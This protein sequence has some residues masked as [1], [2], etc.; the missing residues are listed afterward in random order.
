[1]VRQDEP[2]RGMPAFVKNGTY[3]ETVE[4]IASLREN[5]APRP[6]PADLLPSVTLCHRIADEV[7]VGLSEDVHDNWSIRATAKRCKG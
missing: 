1:M 2:T 5:R 4:F 6:S 3:N 7:C